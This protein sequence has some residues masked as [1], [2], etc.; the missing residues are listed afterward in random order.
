MPQVIHWSP[1]LDD[2]L[3]LLR[4]EGAS[5]DEIAVTIGVSRSA[6]RERGRRIGARRPAANVAPAAART[7]LDPRREPLPPGHPATW[8]PITAGTLLEDSR[9]PMPPWRER[10]FS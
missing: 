3:R 5:W 10:D 8:R 2:A 9:Y 7:L 1:T 4:A 6:A